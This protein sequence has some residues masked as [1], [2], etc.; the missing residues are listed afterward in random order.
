MMSVNNEILKEKLSKLG[1]FKMEVILDYIAEDATKGNL[2]YAEFLDRLVEEELLDKA[3]KLY[4]TMLRFARFPYIKMLE[5]FDFS[6]Q[7]S[8]DERK[9]KELST[10]SFIDNGEN[11]MFLGPPGVGKTHLAV[12]LGLKVAERGMRVHFTTLL[13]MIASLIKAYAEGKLEERMKFLTSPRLLIIDEVGYLPLDKHGSSLFFQLICRRY[14][15]GSII[16]TSNKSYSDW[17]DIFASDSV[18]ASAILDRLLHHSTTINIKGDSYR[19]KDKL[20]AGLVN[21]KGGLA[22]VEV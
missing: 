14:E 2:T 1:L 12:G 4:R 8:I 9:I 13:D 3:D 16:I 21:T 19:L 11:I 18:I 5:D 22:M 6:F 15:K 7:P 10:L 20:K 17:G